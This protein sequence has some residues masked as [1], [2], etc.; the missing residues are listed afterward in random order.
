MDLG[1][2]KDLKDWSVAAERCFLKL[3][4]VYELQPAE[5]TDP[6]FLELGKKY[7]VKFVTEDE[8][9]CSDF[10]YQ[11]A[12][13][14]Q[15]HRAK[16]LIIEEFSLYPLEAISK[17]RIEQVIFCSNLV[18]SKKRAAGTLKVGLHYVDT[19]FID[20]SEFR[21]ELHGRR[22]LHHELYHA[23]D[24]RDT[25]QGYVDADWSRIQ[26]EEFKYEFDA[27]AEMHRQLGRNPQDAMPREFDD[28]Y[29]RMSIRESPRPGFITDYARYSASEDKAEIFCNLMV[30]YKKVMRRAASDAVLKRKVARLKELLV[31]YIPEMDDKFWKK[32]AAIRS[33][34]LD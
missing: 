26:G 19:L 13:E 24:F 12:T 28:P 5:T 6:E 29:N 27:A 33:S 4:G 9:D 8:L 1:D 32:I 22:T 14:L 34:E 15:F 3:L 2:L 7:G 30:S 18:V 23:I 20:L 17:T 10:S 25:W 11:K 21:N 31:Q 16:E